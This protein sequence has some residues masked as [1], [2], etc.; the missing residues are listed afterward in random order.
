MNFLT[1]VAIAIL[2]ATGMKLV[3]KVLGTLLIL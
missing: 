1:M 2:K 3:E